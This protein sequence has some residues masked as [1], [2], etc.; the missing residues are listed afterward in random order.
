MNMEHRGELTFYQ[1]WNKVMRNPQSRMWVFNSRT[2][3]TAE[4]VLGMDNGPILR[5]YLRNPLAK[6]NDQT[7]SNDKKGG[8]AE[9]I[10]CSCYELADGTHLG[11]ELHTAPTDGAAQY[12]APHDGAFD[13]KKVSVCRI[14]VSMCEE[15]LFFF[16]FVWFMNGALLVKLEKWN[17]DGTRLVMR[18]S[19]VAFS[20][21]NASALV[22]TA[23]RPC[24]NFLDAR[25]EYI[26]PGR[27]WCTVEGCDTKMAGLCMF[28]F[29]RG[30]PAC[31][32]PV[33]MLR[34][35]GVDTDGSVLRLRNSIG[36]WKNFGKMLQTVPV[37]TSIGYNIN[38]WRSG[39]LATSSN[40]VGSGVIPL[41]IS[42]TLKVTIHPCLQFHL[43]QS[44]VS[45]ICCT[46]TLPPF[47]IEGEYLDGAD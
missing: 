18:W 7:F 2:P 12:L 43:D 29:I 37:V 46:A 19:M 32:C 36:V 31:M 42:T 21:Q 40:V 47:E 17:F 5:E 34:R 20:P 22:Q 28:C 23:M 9:C 1:A 33:P 6:T 10:V 35:Y 25:F 3:T 38:K 45:D 8:N 26:L 27:T 44:G 39:A 41:N 30:C 13:K 4:L 15:R 11:F 14:V 24:D 16:K